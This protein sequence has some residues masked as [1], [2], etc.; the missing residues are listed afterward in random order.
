MVVIA[1]IFNDLFVQQGRTQRLGLEDGSFDGGY[2]FIGMLAAFGLMPLVMLI[3][4][5]KVPAMTRKTP[6]IVSRRAP[7]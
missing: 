3:A 1:G 5:K 4:E 6:I 2:S 7:R